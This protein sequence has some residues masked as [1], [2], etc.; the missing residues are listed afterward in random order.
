ML[1]FLCW[2]IVQPEYFSDPV[3]NRTPRIRR[4]VLLLVGLVLSVPQVVSAQ[5]KTDGDSTQSASFG[6]PDESDPDLA[7]RI[8]RLIDQLGATGFEQRETAT[9]QLW[10]IGRPAESALRLAAASSN[11]E[12]AARARA[13]LADFD[14][15]IFADTDPNIRATIV[16]FRDGNQLDKREAAR[17][18][19]NAGQVDT[20]IRLILKE[21]QFSHVEPIVRQHFQTSRFATRLISQGNAAA[22]FEAFK[23]L[24]RNGEQ[25]GFSQHR[26]QAVRHELI[27]L[28]KCIGAEKRLTAE[29]ETE[30]QA[31]SSGGTDR[32][33]MLLIRLLR[34]QGQ[35]K[36]SLEQAKKLGDKERSRAVTNNILFE[37]FR[38]K[39]ISDRLWKENRPPITELDV[40]ELLD[41]IT[42]HRLAGNQTRFQKDLSVLLAFSDPI[43][44]ELA[45]DDTSG[46]FERVSNLTIFSICECL[47]VNRQVEKALEYLSRTNRMMAFKGYVSI[48]D[49]MGAFKAIGFP[50][51]TPETAAQFEQVIKNYQPARWSDSTGDIEDLAEVIHAFYTLG[52]FKEAKSLYRSLYTVAT[53]FESN[54]TGALEVVCRSM[55]NNEL[56]ELFFELIKPQLQNDQYEFALTA[57]FEDLEGSHDGISLA[58]FWWMVLEDKQPDVKPYD[59]LKLLHRY[60]RPLPK[61]KRPDPEFEKVV[62]SIAKEYENKTASWQEE[63]YLGFTFQLWNDDAR[64]IKWFRRFLERSPAGP[65]NAEVA[66]RLGNLLWQNGKLKEANVAFRQAR[67]VSSVHPLGLYLAGLVQDQLGNA[68]QAKRDFAHAVM[69]VHGS[70]EAITLASELIDQKHPTDARK[71]LEPLIRVAGF[72]S[73]ELGTA[74]FFLNQVLE[75][76]EAGARFNLTENQLRDIHATLRW[77]PSISG[78]T[79]FTVQAELYRFDQAVESGDPKAA[80]LAATAALKIRPCSATVAEDYLPRLRKMPGGETLANEL[81]ESIRQEHL[82]RLKRFPDSGLYNNNLAWI[83]TTNRIHLQ[84][85]LEH[86]ERA[87]RNEPDNPTYID[88]LA[89]VCFNLGQ[90]DRAIELMQKCLEADPNSEHYNQQIERFQKA[91]Q[92]SKD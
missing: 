49:Y 58:Q 4:L 8:A 36:A 84:E 17:Q 40:P 30:L 71:I 7:A 39:Q 59:R 73:M 70:A 79:Y 32:E 90:I 65:E 56:D 22:A 19:M 28:A 87:V 15:G 62:T 44:E 9:R 34:S 43:V 91:R 1:T 85:A 46:L 14:Y 67:Q 76:K 89:D 88:T 31:M 50:E 13:I 25:L 63:V 42:A 11:A 51:L 75:Q 64:A 74:R 35:A 18:L 20:L 24:D 27:W 37:Q 72:Q 82:K 55:I 29:I 12:V 66:I 81:F 21:K 10:N 53:R 45:L 52:F 61:G 60:L 83:C 54:Q 41:A 2:V 47:F 5:N 48:D 38:W 3:S 92:A 78:Y 68:S 26:Q 33:R 80:H 16:S 69:L 6:T 57:L 86:A 23:L 77:Y